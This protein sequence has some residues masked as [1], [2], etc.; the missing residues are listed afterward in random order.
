ML[1]HHEETMAGLGEAPAMMPLAPTVR[2]P[3]LLVGDSDS[4][5]LVSLCATF[6]DNG[7]IVKATDQEEIVQLLESGMFDAL[8]VGLHQDQAIDQQLSLIK[9]VRQ[10]ALEVPVIVVVDSQSH[11]VRSLSR[12]LTRALHLGIQGLLTLPLEHD[13]VQ[14]T[15]QDAI[16]G[17]Q[18][19]VRSRWQMIQQLVQT[20]K[21]ATAGR[22]VASLAHEMN[23][24]LQALH[25]ALHLLGKRSFNGRKRHQYLQMAQEEVGN[26]IRIVRRMIDLYRPAT[27]GM[28]LT[29]MHSI[30]ETTLNRVDK[31]LHTSNVRVLREWYPRLPKVFA[32]GNRLKQV[33]TDLI[34]NA[35]QAMPHGGTLTIRTYMT[36]G[37]EYQVNAGVEFLPTGTAGHQ[38]KGPSVVV[39]IS[40]TGSGIAADALPR[41]FE[42]FYTTRFHATGLGLAISYSIV[43][44]HQGELSVSSSEGQGT[45]VRLRLPAAT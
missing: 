33:C 44:Q 5:L 29:N 22:I 35:I 10:L 45:T 17:Y 15:V 43:E 40:D 20:E 8:I 41:I 30:L 39:E 42:P 14:Q 23:N 13:E 9:R 34:T 21:L 25:N 19:E 32:I 36:N 28:R 26:L 38:I 4:A 37:T 6:D 7:R 2:G 31:E 11:N 24:P 12:V 27:E 16:A 18:S 3:R 1:H